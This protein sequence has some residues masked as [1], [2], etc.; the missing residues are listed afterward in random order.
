[1]SKESLYLTN[2]DLVF[3]ERGLKPHTNRENC[4]H[5]VEKNDKKRKLI[6]SDFQL[7][8]RSNLVPLP[9]EVHEQLHILMDNDKRYKRDVSVRVY[10]A[11]MALNGEL[12]LVPQRM[13]HT[14]F[15]EI[16]R[17]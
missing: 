9:I 5:I 12:D 17:R 1:M 3:K 8:N 16:M 10:F 13:Y 7:N 11:N 4:H 15:K 14:S 2:R 6:R